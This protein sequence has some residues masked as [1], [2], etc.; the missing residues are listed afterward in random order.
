MLSEVP[1]RCAGKT[2]PK[3]VSKANGFSAGWS[4]LVTAETALLLLLPPGF[5]QVT[6]SVGAIML[7]ATVLAFRHQSR[8]SVCS[9]WQWEATVSVVVFE[10]HCGQS[11]PKSGTG[12]A[13]TSKGTV[14]MR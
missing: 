13:I 5:A 6:G 4:L 1:P 2:P 14:Q 7:G 12:F 8:S 3:D 9:S 11:L 10:L